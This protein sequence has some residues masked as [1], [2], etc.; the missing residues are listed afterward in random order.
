MVVS[1]YKMNP[2]F[3]TTASQNTIPEVGLLI[4]SLRTF[5]GELANAPFWVF[6]TQP[7]GAQKRIH[8]FEDVHTRIIPLEIPVSISR[9]PFCEKVAACALA[10]QNAP[11]GTRSMVWIDSSCLIVQPP[12]LFDL[13]NEFDAAFRPVHIR[14]VGLLTIEPLDPYWQGIYSTLGLEDA[15]TTIIS[16]VD[17]QCL[18]TYFNSHA[19]AIRP[20]LGLMNRWY[21]LF[22]LLVKDKLFQTKACP[23]E[24]HQLFLFQA[25]L[26]ALVASSIDSRRIYILP[27]TYNY[28]YNLQNQLPVEKR[29]N[30]INDLVCFTYEARSIH[31]S[32][33]YDIQLNEPLRSWLEAK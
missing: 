9:Y 6:S 29:A 14:N 18:R 3:L 26:S 7:E 28:P 33:L 1:F 15:S 24:T 27:D 10:E 12:R 11:V 17:G 21:A 13:G 2:L 16:F 20:G 5:G 30:I 23:D 22:Q 32:D 19:F 8:Q 25:L 4:D 31:P